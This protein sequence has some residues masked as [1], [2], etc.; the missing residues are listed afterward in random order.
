MKKIL[1]VVM[2]FMVCELRGEIEKTEYLMEDDNKIAFFITKLTSEEAKRLG[3]AEVQKWENGEALPSVYLH[4]FVKI[5]DDYLALKVK[6]INNSGK[7][8]YLPSICYLGIIRQLLDKPYATVPPLQHIFSLLP[9]GVGIFLSYWLGRGINFFELSRCNRNI[10]LGLSVV[11]IVIAGAVLTIKDFKKVNSIH[12]N[13]REKIPLFE[14]GTIKIC[15]GEFY[16]DIVF[17]DVSEIS[18][19]YLS[20]NPIYRKENLKKWNPNEMKIIPNDEYTYYCDEEVLDLSG[21]KG[22]LILDG[23]L[24]LKSTIKKIVLSNRSTLHF[25]GGL[26]LEKAI[27]DFSIDYVIDLNKADAE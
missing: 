7:N 21:I 18:S 3:D 27:E 26:Y 22:D 25:N 8:I 12:N 20:L 11:P 9:L 15:P 1:L 19:D 10:L 6:V 16:E 17:F 14:M 13:L 23:F 2:I 5:P 24:I 4:R